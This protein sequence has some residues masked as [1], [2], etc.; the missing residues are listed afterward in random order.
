MPVLDPSPLQF[1][2]FGRCEIHLQGR[3]LPPPRYRKEWWLLA[4]LV[5]KHDR[6]LSRDTLAAAFWPDSDPDRALL[7]LRRSLT[8]LRHALGPEAARLSVPDPP[9]PPLRSVRR[10]RRCRRL[11]PSRAND[12]VPGA[13]GGGAGPGGRLVSRAAPAGLYRRVGT[14][15]ARGARAGVSCR[16]GRAGAEGYGATATRRRPSTGSGGW[17]PPTLCARAPAAR[18]WRL[19]RKAGTAP[20]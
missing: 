15:G 17:S 7:Y 1:W 2:L 8:N 6:E 20:P 13:L 5:L 16:P 19:W 9:H 3:P 14:A 12:V 11:R 10:I 18:S 4:L